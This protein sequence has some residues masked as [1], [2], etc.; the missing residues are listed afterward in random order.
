MEAYLYICTFA[1]QVK[2][3]EQQKKKKN[4]GSVWIFEHYL[5]HSMIILK[6]SKTD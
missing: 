5:L 2:I 1:Y 6:M 4:L 3:E